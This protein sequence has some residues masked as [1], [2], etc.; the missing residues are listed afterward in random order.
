MAKTEN[1]ASLHME[2]P[3]GL[4]GAADA[5]TIKGFRHRSMSGCSTTEVVLLVPLQTSS[6]C[7]AARCVKYCHDARR[8]LSEPK[9]A[10]H[11]DRM[12]RPRQQTD[13][14]VVQR[15]VFPAVGLDGQPDESADTCSR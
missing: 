13:P 15:H 8:Q 2:S 10:R 12:R 9:R 6:T 11:R 1:R 7:G 4:D 5:T 3:F 14:D